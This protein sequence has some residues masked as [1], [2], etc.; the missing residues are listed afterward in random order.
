MLLEFNNK[1][2]RLQSLT[3]IGLPLVVIGGWFFP[4]LG[5]FL[6]A[7]M[8]G[9][10][11]VAFY[12][13]RA[14]C[15]WMCPRGSFY[16]LFLQR[17]STKKDIPQFFRKKGFRIFMIVA[18]LS[19]LGG[20]IYFAWPDVN[21]IGLAMVRLLTVTTFV[22]IILGII[23]HHRIWCHFCPMGTISNYMSEGKYPIYINNDKC[24][25]CKVCSKTCPMQLK[26][27]WHKNIGIINDRDCIKCLTCITACSKNAISHDTNLKK[28]A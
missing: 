18:L 2:K 16:D 7:C 10:I 19:I 28:A 17:F 13:G 14:W 23:Y 24:V 4:I 27:Y 8:I 20:Q 1:R 6:L 3:W 25:D 22:G 5:F 21:N 12:K 15:D 26:P 9:A 11:A